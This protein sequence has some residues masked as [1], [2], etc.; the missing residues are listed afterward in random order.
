VT[1]SVE[2]IAL[3]PAGDRF[4]DFHDKIGVTLEDFRQELTGGWLFNYVQA[5]HLAGVRTVLI[6]SSGHVKQP[7]HFIHDPTGCDVTVLPVTRIHQ[8]VRGLR[9]RWAPRS[10][11]LRSLEAYLAMPP[12]RLARELRRRGCD[13]ILCQEYESPKFD[14]A[15]LVGRLLRLPVFGT[16]QGQDHGHSG[17]ERPLRRLAIRGCAGLIVA[18]AG[19]RDRLRRRYGVGPTM[20]AAI[21]NPIDLDTIEHQDKA[22]ARAEL[23]IPVAAQVVVWHGR[24]QVQRKGLDLLVEAWRRVCEQRPESSVVLLMVGAGVDMAELRSLLTTLPPDSF[25]W[26]EE[27]V[28]DRQRL[29]RCLVAADVAVLPSRHEGFPVAVLEAMASGLPVI[30]TDVDGVRE[31]LGSKNGETG[32]IVPSDD[33][34]RLADSLLRA[35][36]EPDAA[37]ARAEESFGLATIGEQLSMTL[38][39]RRA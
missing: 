9:W 26:I 17:A 2:T 16:Y 30:A 25:L 4:E 39:G 1:R 23:G 31:A 15:V 10:S 8:R 20:V 34:D 33:I 38:S 27:Y 19:E 36:G 13:A 22:Q 14:V 21:A 28:R 6:F 18:A 24:V 35:L 32:L 12:H 37:R 3:L 11:V 29:R 7:A 5:L